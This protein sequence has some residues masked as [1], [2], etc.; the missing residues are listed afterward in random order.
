MKN[1]Y[2]SAMADRV[3]RITPQLLKSWGV[4]GL[5]LD[6]DNTLTTHDNPIPDAGVADWLAQN[7]REGI[8]MIVLSNNKP[9]RVEP[10]AKI[11]G[12]DYIADGAKPLKK[13]YQRCARALQIP[14]EQLCM[15]GDQIFTDIWGAR[16]AGCKAVL[17]SPIQRE[18]MLFFRFKRFLER[19]VLRLCPRSIK[20]QI[21]YLG[22]ASFSCFACSDRKPHFRMAPR[23][24]G[25]CV[26]RDI[27]GERNIF[28]RDSGIQEMIVMTREEQA[29]RNA[30][31]YPFLMEHQAVVIRNAK[32]K[33]RGLSGHNKPETMRGCRRGKALRQLGAFFSEKPRR[34]KRLQLG[35]ACDTCRERHG[36]HPIRA[37]KRERGGRRAQLFPSANGGHIVSVGKRL[38]KTDKVSPKTVIMVGAGKVK[39]ESRAHVVDDEQYPVTVAERPHFF[40][41]FS[42]RRTVVRKIAMIIWLCNERRHIAAAG[43]VRRLQRLGIKPWN[44]DVVRHVLRQDTGIIRLHRPWIVSVIITAQEEDFL[45]P[46]MGAGAHDRKGRG[47]R[48]VFH[49]KRP[50]GG[51]DRVHTQLRAF[52]HFIR[53]GGHAVLFFKLFSGGALHIRIPIAE[54]V[55]SICA[56]KIKITVSVDIPKIRA[57]RPL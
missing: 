54:D 3:Y 39:P 18:G 37:G 49:E 26:V 43:V 56:H 13:G 24:S 21:L 6:I 33:Q 47:V 23:H 8:Q 57:L 52:L 36:A 15:V 48:A 16:R 32:I 51:S 45:F 9:H 34:V 50:V 4:R 40:P 25:K 2:P 5:I 17:V 44:D 35:K 10:F 38:A 46:G 30:F 42:R 7:R 55:R 28:I 11:L 27:D 53:G 41:I 22:E 29:A 14:C 19:I 1:L 20:Q 31:R 12:L